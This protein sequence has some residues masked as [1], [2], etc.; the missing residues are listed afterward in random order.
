MSVYDISGNALGSV[1][2]RDGQS[3]YAAF[4]IGGEQVF[5]D[6]N[7]LKV[8][9][10]NVQWFTLLNSQQ[11]MQASI[12][13]G[14]DADIIGLQEISKNGSIPSVGKNVLKAYSTK[15]L[16]NHKNYIAMASK[17]ALSNYVIADFTNQDPQDASQYNETRAYMIADISFNGQTI[18][19][20]N[21]HLCVITA[22]YKWLQ[23]ME[24]YAIAND[25]VSQGYPVIITGDFNSYATSAE[26]DDYIQMFKPFVDDGYKL[27]NNSPAAGFTKTWTDSTSVSTLDGMKHATD[28]IIVSPDISI[29]S[30]VFDTTKFSYLD[31]NPIDHIPVVATIQIGGTS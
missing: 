14:N 5:P 9:T 8:M 16:S 1:Y 20:I 23:M 2:T 24:I 26:D 30:V 7:T 13:N 15:K 28:S 17:L 31:G 10:Y 18:K 25:Y 6:S 11:E 3:L 22:S 4:D 21:T 29:Q 27:A 12:I 19:W